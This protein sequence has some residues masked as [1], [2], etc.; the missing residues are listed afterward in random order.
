MVTVRTP[1]EPDPN[2]PDSNM[3]DRLEQFCREMLS[4]QE[5]KIFRDHFDRKKSLR[6]I[7]N[8]LEWSEARVAQ[9]LSAIRER[10]RRWLSRGNS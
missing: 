1:D 6:Q 9:L 3:R 7:A 10:L 8:E 4:A 5:R 2:D